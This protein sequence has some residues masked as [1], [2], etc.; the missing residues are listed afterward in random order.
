MRRGRD[1]AGESRGRMSG[2][3]AAGTGK[4]NGDSDKLA[5]RDNAIPGEP[6]TDTKDKVYSWF[7]IVRAGAQL[8]LDVLRVIRETSD[9]YRKISSGK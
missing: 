9:L 2:R 5:S 6:G 8:T 4:S 7:D 1:T 3:A